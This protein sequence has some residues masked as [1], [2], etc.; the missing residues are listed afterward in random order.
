MLK[1]SQIKLQNTNDVIAE[2]LEPIIY[3]KVGAINKSDEI[4]NREKSQVYY[5]IAKVVAVHPDKTECPDI[6]V[7]SHIIITRNCF[8]PIQFPVE[9]YDKPTLVTLDIATVFAVIEEENYLT[10]YVESL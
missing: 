5:L 6:I 3:D 4:L 2:L 8:A 1:L 9:G 7:D 10:P